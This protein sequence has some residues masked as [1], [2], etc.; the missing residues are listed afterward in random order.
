MQFWL[1]LECNRASETIG[2]C[3]AGRSL[4]QITNR[5]R[6]MLDIERDAVAED[7]HQEDWSE[8]HKSK[9]YTVMAQLH[10]FSARKCPQP[11][12]ANPR[13]QC[14][15]WN[16]L[17]GLGCLVYASL[18]RGGRDRCR[19]FKI[20]NEDVL[21]VVQPSGLLQFRWSPLRE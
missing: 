20:G 8:Q 4:V 5:E 21:E 7:D 16:P 10:G 6:E 18:G 2:I 11:A 19:L 12:E 1:F 9:P 15:V 13:L 14:F 17:R 3:S